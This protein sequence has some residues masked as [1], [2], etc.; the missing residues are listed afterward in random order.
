MA[1]QWLGARPQPLTMLHTTSA[2]KLAG[3][4]S[5]DHNDSRLYSLVKD[6]W[7]PEEAPR[8]SKAWNRTFVF[9]QLTSELLAFVIYESA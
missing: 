3:A 9:P 8:G 6:Q 1:V 7:T 5:N 4:V 2:I